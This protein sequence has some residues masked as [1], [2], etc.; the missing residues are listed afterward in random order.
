MDDQTDTP[1]DPSNPVSD[2]TGAELDELLLFWFGSTG[3]AP[4]TAFRSEWFR[5][6]DAFDDALR[7]RFGGL[8][9][10]ALRE[11][12][13]FATWRD[14]RGVLAQLI[15]LD[16]LSRNLF[17]GSPRAFE[18]DPRARELAREALAQ[19][20]D[21]EVALVA[22]TFFYLPFEHSED[23]EDQRLSVSLFTRLVEDTRSAHESGQCSAQL[24]TD[25]VMALDYAKKHEDVIAEFGRFPHRNV[26]LGRVSTDA[27]LAWLAAGGGF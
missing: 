8:A 20:L 3:P 12:E 26:A 6:D 11:P 5:R 25:L 2:P 15:L 18:A 17:R 14:A 1:A 19:G 27:E 16:Q 22:R 4:D 13:A 23:R 24:H 21:R 9:E 7:A 10:R